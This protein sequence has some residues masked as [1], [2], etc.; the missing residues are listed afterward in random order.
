M[1]CTYIYTS[2]FTSRK[3]AEAWAE[4]FLH[5]VE[6]EIKMSRYGEAGSR[7]YAVMID[8]TYLN[9]KELREEGWNV[10]DA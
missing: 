1:A 3:K 8:Y 9:A 4:S 2:Q 10:Y 7:R 6:Y 5:G